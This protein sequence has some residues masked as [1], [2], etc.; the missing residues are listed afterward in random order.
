M[1]NSEV[2]ERLITFI[3]YKK[4]SIKAFEAQCGF[5]NGFISNISRC[6][7]AD[8][9][10]SILRP[11]PELSMYWLIDGEGEMLRDPKADLGGLSI[12][13]L[14][15]DRDNERQHHDAQISQLLDQNSELIQQ[16]KTLTELLRV[17][18]CGKNS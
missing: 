18:L 10:L 4:L 5:S 12:E 13:S 3:K 15:R 17:H 8:K 6:I 1:K 7:G 16:N 14:V 9:L 11:Y 2:K